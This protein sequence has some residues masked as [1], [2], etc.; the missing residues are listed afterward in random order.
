[1]VAMLVIEAARSLHEAALE[2]GGGY[3]LEH[4]EQD[5]VV[6]GSGPINVRWLNAQIR[7]RCCCRQAWNHAW[8]K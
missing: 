2:V 6:T 1:M 3:P 8:N 7:F 5:M 4:D